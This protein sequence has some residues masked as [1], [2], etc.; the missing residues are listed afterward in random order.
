MV[1]GHVCACCSRAGDANRMVTVALEEVR[2]LNG[3]MN[4][5]E[6]KFH[7]S[8]KEASTAAFGQS[9]RG[10]DLM[11]SVPWSPGGHHLVTHIERPP[12]NVLVRLAWPMM[13]VMW[14]QGASHRSVWIHFSELGAAGFCKQH[15]A[16]L[17]ACA[18]PSC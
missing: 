4:A 2:Q 16:V 13:V 8:H 14:L 7:L 3:E 17:R 5:L 6:R 11:G 15:G 9:P 12:T 18:N 1:K 10:D